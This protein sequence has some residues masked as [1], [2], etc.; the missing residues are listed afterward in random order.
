MKHFL[1]LLII[2]LSTNCSNWWLYDAD[3]HELMFAESQTTEEKLFIEDQGKCYGSTSCHLLNSLSVKSFTPKQPGENQ[4]HFVF[5][6]KDLG[7]S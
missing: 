6:T 4:Q 3:D 1:I 5:L 2:F 7:F